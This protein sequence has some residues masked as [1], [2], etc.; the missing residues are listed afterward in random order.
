VLSLAEKVIPKRTLRLRNNRLS[1]IKRRM[2]TF[3]GYM[4][5]G[6]GIVAS[7][8]GSLRFLVIVFRHSAAWFLG[9]LL[10]PFADWIYFLL[11]PKQTWKP[12]LI[13]TAGTLAVAIGYW[14]AGLAFLS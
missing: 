3:F 9:C 6:L 14:L 12:T 1:H 4:I 5:F 2:T 8:Y 7:A 10:I 13:S 11:Y